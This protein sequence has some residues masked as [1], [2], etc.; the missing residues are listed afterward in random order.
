VSRPQLRQFLVINRA[1]DQALSNYYAEGDVTSVKKRLLQLL[2]PR[3]YMGRAADFEITALPSRE[4]ILESFEYSRGAEGKRFKAKREALQPVPTLD[5][6]LVVHAG[7]AA[8]TER[9]LINLRKAI[10]KDRGKKVFVG[11]S[12]DLPFQST[13]CWC[14]GEA[15][16]PIFG[17]RHNAHT[18][19]KA[20]ILQAQALSGRNVNV[21]IVDRGLDPNRI[22]V[23]MRWTFPTANQRPVPTP[24][25]HAMMV[26]RSIQEI[27][28]DATI[29]DCALL[30]EHISDI[31]QFITVAH[32]AYVQMLV[33]I[34]YLKQHGIRSTEW[35]FVNAWAIY[36][37]RSEYP[38]GDYTENPNNVFNLIVRQAAIQ[39]NID[40]VFAAGNCGLF[41]PRMNCG[42]DDR[43]PGRS[44]F[45][46]NSHSNVLTTGAV[47]TDDIWLGYSS[48][49]PGQA[50]L[51]QNKPD[52]CSPSQFRENDDAHLVNTGTSASCAVA[53][54]VIAA[55][56]SRPGWNSGRISPDVLR[57][58]LIRTARKTH[59]PMWNGKLGN[60]V[61]DVDA[62]FSRLRRDYP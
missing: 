33:D 54:A 61:L 6:G 48:Q 23:A 56:R 2:R 16:D 36:D 55:L 37:R 62:V 13:D 1:G 42:R 44:I 3:G 15:A 12:A 49:G 43:G 41:C 21:V 27:A 31:G 11:I 34:A 45:G 59:Y 57:D 47:R 20:A 10:G 26:A 28:P 30:P 25:N 5:I 24:Q 19:I 46:A 60:G 50:R 52:L 38:L 29:F 18:A 9:A 4:W 53:A 39:E 40:I 22:N 51:N 14:P 7:N 35:V 8:E 17:T 58:Y 32:S